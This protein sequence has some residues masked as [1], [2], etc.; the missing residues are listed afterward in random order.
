[1]SSLNVYKTD[2]HKDHSAAQLLPW[3]QGNTPVI[4]MR[5]AEQIPALRR[6]EKMLICLISGAGGEKS[7]DLRNLLKDL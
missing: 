4:H 1:M 2:T 6:T 7:S 3:A 5:K